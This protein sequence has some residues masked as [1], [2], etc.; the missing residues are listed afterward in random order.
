[1][2]T[3]EVARMMVARKRVVDVC[4][5]VQSFS[6]AIMDIL[7]HSDNATAAGVIL[8]MI[9]GMNL[10]A[11]VDEDGLLEFVGACLEVSN[12]GRALE[13]LATEGGE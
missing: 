13:S 8:A 3:A 1:M 2:D 6:P 4:R 11:A 5:G 10:R 12:A 9:T 7:E